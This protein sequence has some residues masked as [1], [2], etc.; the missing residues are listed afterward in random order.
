ML[1]LIGEGYFTVDE[2]VQLRDEVE[3]GDEKGGEL[4]VFFA[5]QGAEE[6]IEVGHY[7]RTAGEK[8]TV[9]VESGGL[10]IKVT[11][12]DIGV[13]GYF[14]TIRS[15]AADK[16]YFG[17][18]FQTGYAVYYFNA[19]GLHHFGRGKVVFFVETGFQFHKYSDFLAVLGGGYQGVDDGGV[20]GYA[21]LGYHDFTGFRVV[22]GFI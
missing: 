19:G 21:V 11:G 3:A 5:L 2:A 17:V 7:L 8:A 16:S 12:A 18:Y 15:A 4:R 13:A 10:F 1:A 22:H 6:V 9:G 20:F 14:F